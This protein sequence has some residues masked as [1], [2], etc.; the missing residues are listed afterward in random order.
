MYVNKHSV[1]LFVVILT[2]PILIVTEH[3]YS[4]V[5]N[6]SV[7]EFTVKYEL[8]SYYVPPT[9]SI[10]PYSGENIRQKGH[11]TENRSIIITIKNQA[12][13]PSINDTNYYMY[14]NIRQKGHFG[15]EWAESYYYEEQNPYKLLSMS[16]SEYTVLS[17][18]P[19]YPS[20]SQ[21][22]EPGDQVDFQVEAI[23]Y[24]DTMVRVYDRLFDFV[25]HLELRKVIYDRSGWSETQTLTITAPESTT[26]QLNI[27]LT[28]ALIL[29]PLVTAIGL[30]VYF[31]KRKQPSNTRIM[32]Q[33]YTHQMGKQM[34]FIQSGTEQALFLWGFDGNR[35]K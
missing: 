9:Y 7:P 3:A 15:E 8:T 18:H 11:Y 6:P 4:S 10:D 32:N 29:I 2:A 12:F 20:A 1:I 22:Y 5:A 14:Y 31:R 35:F 26:D 25:G 30:L 28:G 34:F 13:T 17:L 24:Y 33:Q 23:L 19:C 21:D 16:D 27:I